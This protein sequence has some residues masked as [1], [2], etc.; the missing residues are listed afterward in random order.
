MDLH[1][2]QITNDKIRKDSKNE[3]YSR[4]ET[5][6]YPDSI[7]EEICGLPTPQTQNHP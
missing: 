3:K 5:K 7:M 1:N 2:I 4:L 6:I